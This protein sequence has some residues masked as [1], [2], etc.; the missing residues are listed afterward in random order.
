MKKI[1]V[2]E[3]GDVVRLSPVWV[4]L[5][6]VKSNA[7]APAPFAKHTRGV[8]TDVVMRGDLVPRYSVAWKGLVKPNQVAW[9]KHEELCPIN[10][11]IDWDN[12]PWDKYAEDVRSVNNRRNM[13]FMREMGAEI[14]AAIERSITEAVTVAQ[15]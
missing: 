10:V 9:F 3:I 8:I 4:A 7:K 2:F 1:N 11:K 13:E 12:I 15:G 14:K 6:T 5:N